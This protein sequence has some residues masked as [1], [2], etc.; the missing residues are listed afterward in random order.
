MLEWIGIG[1][2]LLIVPAL[3]LVITSRFV[4]A[5]TLKYRLAFV[6]MLTF[7]LG[8]TISGG[9][10]LA[11]ILYSDHITAE[12]SAAYVTPSTGGK[13]HSTYFNLITPGG[14]SSRMD[15]DYVGHLLQNGTKVRI[16]YLQYD[17]GVGT[18]IQM[19]MIEDNH[20]P[21]QMTFSDGRWSQIFMMLLGVVVFSA[22]F[23]YRTSERRLV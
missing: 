6:A 8:I 16:T 20:A 10:S 5:Q 9:A 19:K 14:I 21:S 15:V 2:F 1:S 17:G 12:G 18:V 11:S 3:L 4:K 22:G 23:Y 13:N 7:G